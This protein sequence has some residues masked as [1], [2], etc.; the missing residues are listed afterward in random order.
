MSQADAV[1]S[2]ESARAPI[3]DPAEG[4]AERRHFLDLRRRIEATLDEMVDLRRAA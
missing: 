4:Y 1:L 3:S 2:T